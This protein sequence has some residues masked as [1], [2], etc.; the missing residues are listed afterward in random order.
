MGPYAQFCLDFYDTT[1]KIPVNLPPGYALYPATTTMPPGL[2]PG[3]P[4]AGFPIPANGPPSAAM[5]GQLRSWERNLRMESFPEGEEK[6]SIPEGTYVMLRRR[7]HPDFTF[8]IPTRQR[9]VA[10]QPQLVVL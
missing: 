3:Y 8:Q 7:G 4:P 5:G 1:R 9:I 10:A 6:W 2:G